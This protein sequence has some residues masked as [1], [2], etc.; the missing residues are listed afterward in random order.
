VSSSTRFDAPACMAVSRRGAQRL[1]LVPSRERRFSKAT[2]IFVACAV[3]VST[4]GR[5]C[6][7]GSSARGAPRTSGDAPPASPLPRRGPRRANRG[8]AWQ[9]GR[10]GGDCPD[11]RAPGVVSGSWGL[12]GRASDLDSPTERTVS[13][14]PRRG[15]VPVTVTVVPALRAQAAE[16]AAEPELAEMQHLSFR[17]SQHRTAGTGQGCLGTVPLRARGGHAQRA[18]R[19]RRARDRHPRAASG[20]VAGCGPTCIRTPENAGRLSGWNNITTMITHRSPGA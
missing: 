18:C 7:D 5:S 3:N 6:F 1:K 12:G 20:T 19:H 4:V 16:E 15:Q 13:V 8:H 11:P 10:P 2:A 17:F 14:E 9:R